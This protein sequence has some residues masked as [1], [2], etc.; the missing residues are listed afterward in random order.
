[1]GHFGG[2]DR[3]EKIEV[4]PDQDDAEGGKLGKSRRRKIGEEP[5]AENWGRDDH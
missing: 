5:K 1:L 2:A 3:A 4:V